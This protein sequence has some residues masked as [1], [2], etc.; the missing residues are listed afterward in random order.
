MAIDLYKQKFD[1]HILD[2]R[3]KQLLVIAYTWCS[4]EAMCHTWWRPMYNITDQQPC[5]G[6]W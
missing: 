3:F 4:L 1:V 5:I 2:F 6:P